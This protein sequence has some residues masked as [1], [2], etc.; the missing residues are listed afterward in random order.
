MQSYTY[1]HSVLEV[2][3]G[4]TTIP[5][6][7]NK[8]QRKTN[9]QRHRTTSHRH[10]N[11]PQHDEEKKPLKQEGNTSRAN[12]EPS[13]PREQTA[14]TD[15]NTSLDRRT[16]ESEHLNRRNRHPSTRR[17]TENYSQAKKQRTNK[18]NATNDET[19]Y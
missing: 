12:P 10:N 15:T 1:T 4:K 2:P 17:P 7:E 18:I 6:L 3:H 9:A 8:D 13:Q 16:S 5:R 19:N 11:T 14:H